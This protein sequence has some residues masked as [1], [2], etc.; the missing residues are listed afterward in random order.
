M[1]DS[2]IIELYFERS[3]DAIKKTKIKYGNFCFRIAQNIL[4][5]KEDAEE[6]ENDAYLRAWNSISPRKPA[7]LKSYLG[8]IVRNLALQRYEYYSAKKRNA[9]LEIAFSELEECVVG[10]RSVE[11]QYDAGDLGRAVS[12]FLHTIDREPRI[13]FVRRYWFTDSVKEIA[14]RFGISESKVKS[15]LFRTRNKL[16][17][18]L[19]KGG[20]LT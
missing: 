18:Y 1:D 3:E 13:L 20:F 2:Q 14:A 10:S 17:V 6:C 5:S 19:Q 12:R 11:G 7:V 16:K 4:K 9:E 15:S 8:K